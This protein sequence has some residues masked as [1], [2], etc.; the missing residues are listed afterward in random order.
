M[1]FSACTPLRTREGP[2]L[3][4]SEAE[5]KG[6]RVQ[7]VVFDVSTYKIVLYKIYTLLYYDIPWNH[8]L[9]VQALSLFSHCALASISASSCVYSS[10]VVY[11]F[12]GLS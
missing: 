12:V 8:V 10:S 6:F 9:T 5:G 7:G 1:A 2:S 3:E 4:L 11:G